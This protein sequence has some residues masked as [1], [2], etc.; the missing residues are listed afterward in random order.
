MVRILNDAETV[1]TNSHTIS[2][3]SMRNYAYK[4]SKYT[5]RSA[6]AQFYLANKWEKYHL[7]LGVLSTIFSV[8][9]GTSLLSGSEKYETVT[10][11]LALVASALI[12]LSTFLN[13]NRRS[14]EH[15]TA[16]TSFLSISNKALFIYEV[17]S[18]MGH[19][20]NEKLMTELS[21][22][23]KNRDELTKASP[24]IPPMEWE[25]AKRELPKHFEGI[26][27]TLDSTD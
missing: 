22:L 8:I 5:Y 24:R 25:K 3:D 13:P 19:K 6:L 4:F 7:Y 1:A 10:G 15:Y 20:T 14:Q 26:E 12:A 9:A 21:E 23:T 16:A 27:L 18:I 17:E 11:L 2:L